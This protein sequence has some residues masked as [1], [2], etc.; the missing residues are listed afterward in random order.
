MM[1]TYPGEEYTFLKISRT[2]IIK[3]TGYPDTT[4][5]TELKSTG[6]NK[7]LIPVWEQ[8]STDQPDPWQVPR[9][10][11]TPYDWLLMSVAFVVLCRVGCHGVTGVLK[12][13]LSLIINASH[14]HT[15]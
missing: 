12:G 4:K 14:M 11:F 15:V 6:G 8:L 7:V 2:V 1:K 9:Q 3:H 5:A 13:I 10:V